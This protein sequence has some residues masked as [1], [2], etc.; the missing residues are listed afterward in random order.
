MSTTAGTGPGHGA[1]GDRIAAGPISWGV[2]E[3][4][5]WG[6]QLPAEQVLSE[7]R[8]LGIVATEAGPDGYLGDDAERVREPARPAAA[9]RSSAASCP[10]SSTIPRGSTRSLAKVRRTAAFFAELGGARSLLGRVVDDEWSAPIE[11]TDAQWDHLLAALPL[12]DAVAAEHGVVHALHPH[13][14]TL[15]ERDRRRQTASLEGSDVA[16]CLDT[17]HL[18]LGG[19]RPAPRSSQ[20]HPRPRRA[21]APQ[22]RRRRRRRS[23]C[24]RA[25]STSS[26]PCRL[27]SSGRSATGDARV[28]EVVAA[29]ERAGLRGW[30]VLEQDTALTDAVPPPGARPGRRRPP[31]RRV[32]GRRFCRRLSRVVATAEGR[33]STER[34]KPHRRWS[35]TTRVRSPEGEKG[36]RAE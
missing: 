13:W 34:V 26:A 31:E 15:V 14:G 2:C 21:R 23:A 25:S 3:V 11:L 1:G 35:S 22:R 5:N 12:L 27:G 8:S 4:P 30:Y 33:R 29:L 18:A 19:V 24:G 17:G 6:I 9:S 10:S 32:P 20:A 36:E 28:G 7:M 16:I